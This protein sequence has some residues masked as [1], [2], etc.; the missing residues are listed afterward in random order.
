[1]ALISEMMARWRVVEVWLV[2]C[3]GAGRHVGGWAC[4]WCGVDG[5]GLGRNGWLRVH[6][7]VVGECVMRRQEQGCC[8]TIEVGMLRARWIIGGRRSRRCR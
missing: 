5:W 2:W 7:G 6:Q 8:A 3:P 4:A 1:M